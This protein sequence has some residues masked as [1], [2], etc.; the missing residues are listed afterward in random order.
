MSE[1]ENS[2]RM[3]Y[4]EAAFW[5]YG[6]IPTHPIR[7]TEKVHQTTVAQNVQQSHKNAKSVTSRRHYEQAMFHVYG[8]QTAEI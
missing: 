6:T 4:E 7:F 5:V 3:K 2:W 8:S 1:E